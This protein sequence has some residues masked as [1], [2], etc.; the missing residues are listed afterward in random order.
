MAHQP[1]PTVTA[2]AA[3]LTT[4]DRIAK[5]PANTW[6]TLAAIIAGVFLVVPL[7]RKL[8]QVSG[9][10]IAFAL[11]LGVVLLSAHW[12]YHRTEPAILKPFVDVVAPFFRPRFNPAARRRGSA[13]LTLIGG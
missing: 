11:F 12:I 5:V 6:W 7:V 10:W 3:T 13:D 1:D 2:I 9:M 4:L 8:R